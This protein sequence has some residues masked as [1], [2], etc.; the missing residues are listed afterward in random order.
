MPTI[1][2]L[3][4][5]QALPLE[6]KV[7]K[8]KERIK[9]FVE[10]I[11]EENCYV[12]FSGGKDSSVL[13][14]IARELY[15][16]IEGVF[17]DTGLEY[18]EIREFVKTFD[19][20]TWLKPEMSFRDVIIKYGYPFISK[21]VSECVYNAKKYLESINSGEEHY[22]AHYNKL[23]GT[24]DK[25]KNE[26]PQRVQKVMGT[27]AFNVQDGTGKSSYNCEKYKP[28]LDVDFNISHLCCGEMKKKIVKKYHRKVNKSPLIATMTNESRQRQS[29]WLK[30]GCNSFDGNVASKPMSFWTEQD[31]LRYV[32]Q[33]NIPIASVY[34]EI[35]DV[36]TS[37][38]NQ[39]CFEGFGK[40]KCTECQ[41][42][43]CI[44]CGFGAHRDT[45]GGGQSR[46]VRLK[47]THP[48]LYDYCM[49]GG[50]YNEQGIWQ[51]SKDGLGMKHCIDVLN[52]LYSKNGKKFI[53]Y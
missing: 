49:R 22:L 16:N 1:E 17:C 12:S 10:M 51:P 52:D 11:G 21:E 13:L 15:P 40:L 32:R 46:F 29:A 33:N 27:P 48:K 44:F 20:I 53:E 45:L 5:M 30:T 4:I 18:P 9:E 38:E 47:R 2:E 24:R 8:T 42:T 28:L 36:S 31:V 14:N 25:S 23:M 43:G 3:K 39:I 19:N 26:V 35:V 7:L 6:L 41:R 37:D 50:E 34:G